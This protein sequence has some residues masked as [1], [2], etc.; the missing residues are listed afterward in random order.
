MAE[1]I[2][3]ESGLYEFGLTD[4]KAAIEATWTLAARSYVALYLLLDVLSD[5]KLVDPT[6][7]QEK[8]NEIVLA[9]VELISTGT[10]E[11]RPIGELCRSSL[12]G[13][14]KRLIEERKRR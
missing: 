7:I 10:R 8:T 9:Q 4:A 2:T 13:M 12:V 5:L 11:G 3:P 14:A 1:D 6:P